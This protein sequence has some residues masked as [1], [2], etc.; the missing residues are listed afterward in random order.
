MLL[1]FLIPYAHVS[2]QIV[3]LCFFTCQFLRALSEESLHHLLS[4]A[5]D[6]THGLLLL[7]VGVVLR[8]LASSCLLRPIMMLCLPYNINKVQ[9]SKWK[10]PNPIIIICTQ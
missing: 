7:R 5:D 2:P 1:G 4:T 6:G 8:E 3:E 10:T 9:S